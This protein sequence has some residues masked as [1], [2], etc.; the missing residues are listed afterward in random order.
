ALRG[1]AHLRHEAGA[2]DARRASEAPAVDFLL[3]R[4]A[5]SLLRGRQLNRVPPQP[6]LLAQDRQGAE[7]VSAVQRK[8]M[9]QNVEDSQLHQG[10]TASADLTDRSTRG[11]VGVG[12]S[13]QRRNA[14]NIISVHNGAL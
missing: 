6:A 5:G 9:V 4:R 8:T 12:A 11:S 7:G 3:E 14:S 10:A 2:C 13:T 1:H